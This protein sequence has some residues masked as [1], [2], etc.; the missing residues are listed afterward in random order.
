MKRS[1]CII[2]ILLLALMVTACS[3]QNPVGQL[4]DAPASSESKEETQESGHDGEQKEEGADLAPT[5]VPH[6][7]VWEEDDLDFEEEG[8][9]QPVEVEIPYLTNK[10]FINQLSQEE[11]EDLKA[12]YLATTRF[13]ERCFY[14]YPIT[15][16]QND[17]LAQLLVYE[18]PEMMQYNREATYTYY[19]N[20][21]GQVTS[22]TIEYTMDEAEWRDKVAQ[23]EAVLE[24]ME[25]EMN[26]LSDYEK[27]L[28]IYR[29]VIKNNTYDRTTTNAENPYGLLIENR[30][31][32]DGISLTFKWLMDRAGIPNYILTGRL[33]D[34][35]DGHAWNVVKIDG[36]WYDLDITHDD[37]DAPEFP[38]L[39]IY[40][41]V[42]VDRYMIRGQYNLQQSYQ[43]FDL[44]GAETM[45]GCY[46]FR[47]W[48][49]ILPDESV[50]SL[51]NDMLYRIWTS[52]SEGSFAFQIQETSMYRD[53]LDN[54]Q[55]Y[56]DNAASYYGFSYDLVWYYMDESQAIWFYVTFR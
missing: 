7:E 21:D 40:G 16:E 30:A 49:Y 1:R 31:K 33:L 35:S 15:P 55:S 54:T 2:L 48:T 12:L 6:E 22:R 51:F 32:C 52:G 20:G 42:N 56:I 8:P 9:P 29:Y 17:K 34:D 47:N 46:H 10:Y 28:Y 25:A 3:K 24:Q 53:F 14:P 43:Y 37:I 13:E 5:P 45:E 18:C 50:Q 41:L 36:S 23:V 44:P 19:T 11:M 4:F 27:E 39:Y 38:E 26:G